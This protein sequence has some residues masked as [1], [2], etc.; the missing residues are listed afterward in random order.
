MKPISTYFKFVSQE[1]KRVEY[2][3][4]AAWNLEYENEAA[5]SI[6]IGCTT[7]TWEEFVAIYEKAKSML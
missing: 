1:V 2:S 6:K 7:G 5:K 4:G 3:N